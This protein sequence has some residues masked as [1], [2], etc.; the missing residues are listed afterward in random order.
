MKSFLRRVSSVRKLYAA[1]ELVKRVTRKKIDKYRLKYSSNLHVSDS[2]LLKIVSCNSKDE[3]IHKFMSKFSDSLIFLDHHRLSEEVDEFPQLKEQVIERA[4]KCMNNHFYLFERWIENAYDEEAKHFKWDMDLFAQYKYKP[5]Y[6]KEIRQINNVAGVDLKLPWEFSRMHNLLFLAEAYLIT[7]D[8][9]YAFKVVNMIKD[10]IEC[11]PPKIGVNWNCTMDVGLRIA[12]MVTAISL[13]KESPALDSDFIWMFMKS[14]YEHGHHI[15][16]N[17]EN[18]QK[19]TDNH[20][21]SNIFGLLCLSAHIRSFSVSEKW[22]RFSSSK[23]FKA[24]K[25]QTYSDGMNYEGSTSYHRLVGELFYYGTI[26]CSRSGIGFPSYFLPTLDKIAEFTRTI[27]KLDGRIPQIGDNDSGRVFIMADN[28]PLDHRYLIDLIFIETR[29]NYSPSDFHQ[30]LFWIYGA[31]TANRT[32][33]QSSKQVNKHLVL[34]PISKVVVYKDEELYL[35]VS[36]ISNGV[37]RMG[38]HTH[39]D[40]L[41]FELQYKGM[42]FFV[43]PG[44]GAYTSFKEIRNSFRSTSLH[45]TVVVN[46]LEQSVISIDSPFVIDNRSLKTHLEIKEENENQTIIAGKH[47][48]Y[49]KRLK[50][51]HIREYKI[52]K[53]KLITVV[54]H[55]TGQIEHLQWNFVLSPI[56]EIQRVSEN[57]VILSNGGCAIKFTSPFPVQII[58]GMYSKGYYS[59]ED[60]QMLR[61]ENVNNAKGPF[62]TYI[63]LL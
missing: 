2:K 44:T 25:Q 31:K 36:A 34:F 7:H 42:D 4:E 15:M 22:L 56:V 23:L 43:D 12:N 47:N 9:R 17:L 39:N 6:Y 35:I 59:W 24:I 62:N 60:T 51:E 57:E 38:G 1:Q 20:Y 11:N 27:T 58:S 53:D 61:F 54:D 5:G 50:T 33:Q 18:L 48:G 13:I 52:D 19:S 16:C 8:D 41:S 10:W 26:I 30:E 29:N 55:F 3:A 46:K 45:N 63:T 14:C 32:C 21:L 37:S 49:F 40:K 28:D